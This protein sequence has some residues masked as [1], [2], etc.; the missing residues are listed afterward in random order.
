MAQKTEKAT[1]KKL[2]DARKKG[3]VAKSQ[4]FPS[5]LTFITAIMS[6]LFAAGYIFSQLGRYIIAMFKSISYDIDV[7]KRA[8]SFLYQAILLIFSTSIPIMVVVSLVGVITNFLVIG[9]LF[10]FEALKFQWKRLN[11]V[12]GIKQKFKLKTLV[13]LI[14]SLLKIIGAAIIIYFVIKNSLSEVIATV[15]IPAVGSALFLGDFLRKIA[16]R[17]GLFF[18]AVAVFDLAFQKKDFAKQMMM[19]KFE[20]KQELKDTEGDPLIKGKRKEAFREIAYREGPSIARRSKA[21][22]TNPIHIAV[23]IDYVED[24][25]PAPIILTMGQGP[26]ADQIVKIALANHVPIMR[27]PTLAQTL[28]QKGTISDYI[29]EETYETV[30]T[31][32]KWISSLEE[33]PDINTELFQT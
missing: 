28:F 33:N 25:D 6:T 18:L 23:A 7:G 30:A 12:E 13:E 2:K 24:S 11:P 15:Q 29:P 4:D 16:I 17:I 5:A 31:I 26:I 3:Q 19:E 27:N 9:P 1:P 32:L 20:I 10:S 8:G 21:V 14:K 22:I